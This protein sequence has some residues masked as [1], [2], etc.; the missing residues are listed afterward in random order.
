MKLQKQFAYKYKDSKHYKWVVVI[1][2]ETL[3]KL[4]WRN[5]DRLEPVIDENKLIV[6]KLIVEEKRKEVE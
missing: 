4:G 3:R 2:E 5:G 6:K 1:P